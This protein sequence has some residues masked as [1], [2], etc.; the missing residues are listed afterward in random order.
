MRYRIGKSYKER[1]QQRAENAAIKIAEKDRHEATLIRL[2]NFVAIIEEAF[3]PEADRLHANV[4]NHW[5]SALEFAVQAGGDE[6]ALYELINGVSFK[7]GVADVLYVSKT[8]VEDRKLY[9]RLVQQR[10]NR[11]ERFSSSPAKIVIDRG[12]TYNAAKFTEFAEKEAT[13]TVEFNKYKLFHNITKYLHIFETVE[14][15]DRKVRNS[16]KGFEGVFTLNT[17]KGKYQFK[18]EAI[19][20]NGPIIRFHYRYIANLSAL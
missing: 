19:D 10:S 5:I 12:L 2:Q 9:D 11:W 13:D 6:K 4:V 3:K 20:V 18:C 14:V 16:V 15:L 7:E 1:Q 17:N 8:N